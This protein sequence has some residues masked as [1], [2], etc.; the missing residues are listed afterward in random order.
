MLRIKLN[1]K[2]LQNLPSNSRF[3]KLIKSC[4]RAPKGWLYAACDYEALEDK[5]SAILSKDK[6]KTLEFSQNM[7][8]HSI[9]ALAF[10][11]EEL[12][13]INMEKVDEV[14][15]I[16]KDF[17][18][19]R[20]KAKAP[21]FAL[22]YNGTWRTIQ[23]T[24]GCT[25]TKAK[26]IEENYH[27]LYSGLA[28]FSKKNI[29]FA[30]K[31]GYVECAFGLKLRTPRLDGTIGK[32]LTPEQETEGRSCSNAVTQSYGM[33]L[34]RAS[35]EF[36]DLINASPYRDNIRLSNSIH[37]CIYA[38]VKN[39]ADTIKFY[40]D[41]LIKCMAW[42]EDPL[43]VSNDIKLSA[44]VDYGKSWDKQYTLKNNAT[45]EEIVEFMKERELI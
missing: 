14:N 44:A 25:P 8:G 17:P 11:P 6:M 29:D 7:D 10:F 5:I 37:D 13:E 12:P 24:L 27:K 23:K 40:N 22:Q 34:N 31:N 32:E 38:I 39:D 45:L 9:R 21:S 26:Q 19:I 4:I 36:R 41:T 16:K 15:S 3:G 2:N 33:L 18:D 1:I 20:Q 28:E 30:R 42:Q 35:I 43:L